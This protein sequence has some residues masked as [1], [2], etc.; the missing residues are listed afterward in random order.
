M[1]DDIGWFA[2]VD[3]ASEK[4]KVCLLNAN[5]LARFIL[6]P[7]GLQGEFCGHR[8]AAIDAG[9]WGGS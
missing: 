2:G 7:S 9:S 5:L 8:H 6:V 3:W 1:M 4:H